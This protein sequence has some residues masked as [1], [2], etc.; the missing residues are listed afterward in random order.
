M[1]AAPAPDRI[2][3]DVWTQLNKIQDQLAVATDP[4]HRQQ[5]EASY[6]SYK[7]ILDQMPA[8]PTVQAGANLQGPEEADEATLDAA[9]GDI[10]G[11]A[12]AAVAA[13]P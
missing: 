3:H 9:W 1:T 2:R 4:V 12:N 5:L 13:M 8:A 7:A 11:E 6:R 10:L